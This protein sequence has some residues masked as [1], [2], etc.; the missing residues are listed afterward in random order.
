MTENKEVFPKL[1]K[2]LNKQVDSFEVFLL[3]TKAITIESQEKTVDTF[4]ASDSSGVS[5]RVLKDN[6]PGFAFSSD[7]SQD[8]L[9][10]MAA[11][12]VSQTSH[13]AK[14]DLLSFPDHQSLDADG[15]DIFDTSL[16]TISVDEKIKTAFALEDAALSYD[17]KIKRVRNASYEE[18]V[19]EVELYNS[20][21]NGLSFATTRVSVGLMSIAQDGED[22]QMGWDAS[23]KIAFRDLDVAAVGRQASEKAVELLNARTIESIRVP[24]LLDNLVTIGLLGIL[25]SSFLGDSVEKGKSLLK[26]KVGKKV[27]SPKINIVDN[28][29]L[30]GGLATAPFDG[31]GA[32]TQNTPLVEKG[33]CRGFLY[34]TYWAKRSGNTS[35]GNSKRGGFMVPPSVGV[36]NLYIEKGDTSFSKLLKEVDKG[37]YITE[38]MGL[39]TANPITGDFSVGAAGF[40]IEDGE[41]TFPVRGIAISG[42][43][44][45]LFSQVF[46]VGD[47]IRFLGGLGAPGIAVEGIDVSA[48]G[49]SCEQA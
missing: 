48:E 6:S 19:Q 35:T 9:A 20:E 12:A 14:D 49:D 15:L 22:S 16:G 17:P 32:P 2:L 28:G 39:H 24:L 41:K 8:A 37:I 7:I 1:K 13:S 25:S 33:V 4:K 46:A 43:I 31:E 44:L 27:F 26:G 38:L 21:G 34:D 40:W 45:N 10:K 5:L 18:V 36:S 47:D 29:L 30:H 42:N 23:A 3:R 11:D